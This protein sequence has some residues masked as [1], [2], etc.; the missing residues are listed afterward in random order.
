MKKAI[1]ILLTVVMLLSLG[2]IA[3]A[4]EFIR[5]FEAS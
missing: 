4:E 1:S 5:P 3:F 2:A